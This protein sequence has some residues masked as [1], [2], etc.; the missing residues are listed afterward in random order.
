MSDWNYLNWL[1][2][3]HKKENWPTQHWVGPFCL[4]YL[5]SF[6]IGVPVKCV[7]VSDSLLLNLLRLF[8]ERIAAELASETIQA[9]FQGDNYPLD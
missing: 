2:R 8:S 5:E 6:V 7:R 4:F 9:A 1:V 3:V